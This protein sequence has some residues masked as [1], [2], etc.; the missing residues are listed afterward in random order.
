[1]LFSMLFFI[2]KRTLAYH[3]QKIVDLWPSTHL[4]QEV[5][6]S[7]CHPTRKLL[8]RTSLSIGLLWGYDQFVFI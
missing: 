8:W 2:K 5:E 6:N 1:M 3:P 4:Y 7:K